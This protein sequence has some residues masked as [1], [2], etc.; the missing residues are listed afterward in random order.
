MANLK[1]ATERADQAA[2][3]D[4]APLP[5]EAGAATAADVV[6]AR[7]LVVVP[8]LNEAARIEDCLRS[9]IPDAGAAEVVV[10][11]GGSTDGTCAIV[12][13]LIAAFPHLSLQ[14]NDRAVQAAAV[15]AAAHAAPADRDILVR[16]DAHALYPPHYVRDLVTTL[17]AREVD[18]VVVPMD[19]VPRPGSGRIERAIALSLDSPLGA[20]GAPHRGGRTS[21]WVDHGHHAAFR[22]ERF[23][24]LGGYDPRFAVNEDAEFDTRLARA[25][26]RI[27]LDADIRVRY[28]PRRSL[29]ALWRQYHRYGTYRAR[30]ARLHRSRLKLRQL[31]PAL[32]PLALLASLL[33]MPISPWL[34]AIYPALY[35]GLLGL[36]A[37]GLGIKHKAAACL[38]SPLIFATLHMAWGTGFLA[39][40]LSPWA[41]T[42]TS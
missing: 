38:L 4:P 20:G 23:L 18:S 12:E 11:D 5:P 22:R 24:A 39:G 6:L 33:M 41:D 16:C 31:G 3:P 1:T 32:H 42:E 8:T 35:L 30:H 26:G 7:V 29:T 19:T 36:G 34:A 17:I 10:Y 13:R 37:L 40:W 28:F 27:W 25:G 14:H 2:V 21:G 9:L 15:N